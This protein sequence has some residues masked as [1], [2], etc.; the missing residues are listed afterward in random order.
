MQPEIVDVRLKDEQKLSDDD[1]NSENLRAQINHGLS[2]PPGHK[3]LP[4]MLL[5]DERGLRLYDVLTT[6][7]KEYYLF[8]CVEPTYKSTTGQADFLC[9]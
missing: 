6:N 9:N 3:T 1:S 8:G 7:V 4:T 2:K 5:Y